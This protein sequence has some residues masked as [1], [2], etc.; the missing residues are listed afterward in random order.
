MTVRAR[1]AFR[2]ADL[3]RALK[4]ATAAGLK[5]QRFE[6]TPDGRIIVVTGQPESHEPSSLLEAWKAKRARQEATPMSTP[7]SPRKAAR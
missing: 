3:T 1:V 6:I 7:K 5:V 4:A 2:Q